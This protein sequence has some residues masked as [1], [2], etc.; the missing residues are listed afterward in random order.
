LMDMRL[1]GGPARELIAEAI[2]AAEMGAR[3]TGRL[4]TFARRRR[5][6]P[7][8]LDLND[9]VLGMTELLRRAIGEPIDLSTVLAPDLWPVKVDPSEIENAIVNLAVNARD[10]MPSGGKLVIRTHNSPIGGAGETGLPPGDYVRLSVSDNGTGMTPEVLQ[11]AFEPFFT[12]KEHGRGTGL[13][14]STIYGFV[15]QS[16]GQVTIDSE[17]GRGTTVNLFLPRAAAMPAEASGAG[18]TSGVAATRGELVLVVEDNPQVRRLAVR[19]LAELGYRVEE[20][21]TAREALARIGAGHL[22]DIV[23]SDVVMPGGMSGVDLALALAK[24]HPRV[25]VLL[26]S[27]FTGETMAGGNDAAKGLALL[28]KPYSLTELSE[29]LRRVLDGP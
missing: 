9:Q 17:P 20:A 24:S 28:R 6:D 8:V 12:T 7:A 1:G 4:L 23:F 26:T 15:R 18:V 11:R 14:L 5:L 27:G 22:P 21:E 29:A 10:A 19:R 25:K 13:G 2:E 16:G 3:L